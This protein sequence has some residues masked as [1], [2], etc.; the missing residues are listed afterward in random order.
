MPKPISSYHLT[1]ATNQL[2][3]NLV[4]GIINFFMQIAILVLTYLKEHNFL[5]MLQN[6]A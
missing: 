2:L 1:F 6:L 4:L 5:E 3:S